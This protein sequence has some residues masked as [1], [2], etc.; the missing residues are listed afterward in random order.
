MQNLFCENFFVSKAEMILPFLN[1]HK[2]CF[3]INWLTTIRA[4]GSA[5]DSRARA[6]GFNTLSGHIFSFLPL[7]ILE[8]QWSVT[9]E[10]MC[11]EYW[12]TV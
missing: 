8:G 7:L 6:P 5:S 10:S 4:I 1:I 2:Y 12:L 9:G 11:M 3:I